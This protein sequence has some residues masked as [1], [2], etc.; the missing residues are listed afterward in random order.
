MPS[1]DRAFSKIER[2]AEQVC[3]NPIRFNEIAA[4][5]VIAPAPWMCLVPR[6]WCARECSPSTAFDQAQLRHSAFD[7]CCN[8]RSVVDRETDLDLRIRSPRGGS[9]WLGWSVWSESTTSHA[10]GRRIGSVPARPLQCASVAA[11]EQAAGESAAGTAEMALAEPTAYMSAAT[12]RATV[13]THTTESIPITACG[14]ERKCVSCQSPGE[15]RSR[16]Q[17]DHGLT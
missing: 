5:Q 17:N 3:P 16:S 2:I 12:E 13:S 10:S 9:Q 6:N 11:S 15:S 7:C 4:R 8:L 1:Y 14:G